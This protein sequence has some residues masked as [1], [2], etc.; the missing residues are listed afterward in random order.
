MEGVVEAVS[1]KE[2]ET[3]FGPSNKVGLKIDGVWYSGFFKKRP[4]VEKGDNVS[5]DVKTNGEYKNI[6]DKTF[7]VVSGTPSAPA[8]PGKKGAARNGMRDGMIVNNVISLVVAGSD[9][10]QAVATVLKVVALVENDGV[11]PEPVAEAPASS[12][13]EDDFDD[14]FPE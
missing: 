10:E 7:K 4:T 1:L 6:V 9:V 13:E 11:K 3:R 8:A 5:F 12:P 14:D 2:V